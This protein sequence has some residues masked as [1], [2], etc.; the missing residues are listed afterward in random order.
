MENRARVAERVIDVGWMRNELRRH[1]RPA[2]DGFAMSANS[3][4]RPNTSTLAAMSA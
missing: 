1:Q 4:S 2:F 3:T